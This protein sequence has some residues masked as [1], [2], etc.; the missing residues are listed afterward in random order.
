MSISRCAGFAGM[1]AVTAVLTS[2]AIA[3][4]RIARECPVG[5][6]GVGSLGF[7]ELE[8]NCTLRFSAT[9]PARR[10]YE[11]RAEPR[12][13][14]IKKGRP[15]DGKLRDGDVIAAIDGYLI[16]T[17]EGGRRFAQLEPGTPVTVTVRRGGRT[18]DV[19]LTPDVECERIDRPAPPAPPKAPAAAA[20][21]A[22][23]APAELGLPR[24]LPAPPA[25]I[26]L[27][28]GRLGF[29]IRCSDC[30]I[31][32]SKP[33]GA[34]VWTFREHP[35]IERIELGSP[36]HEEG[37]RGG[38]ILTH[39]NDVSLTTDEGGRL[40]GA[41]E[42]GDTVHVRYVRNDQERHAAI[43]AGERHVI[44]TPAP[45]AAPRPTED[46][47]RFS[48]VLGDAFIQVTGGPITVRRTEG[49]VVIR[50]QDITVRIRTTER[51]EPK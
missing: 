48:G 8:C 23:K 10:L 11:F 16:T 35:I 26:A 21:P 47:T 41:V 33:T 13:G 51:S 36:A 40:F 38:D 30:V 34:V 25:P 7:S 2:S 50:S 19:T 3:Q 22:P 18:L 37:M 28:K 29:S 5:T 14:G 9:D 1:I 44:I 12:I 31:Q 27:P 49:E 15:A 24:A 42:P 39:I 46:V 43:V 6:Q 17:R 4:D 45:T 32:R 20:A